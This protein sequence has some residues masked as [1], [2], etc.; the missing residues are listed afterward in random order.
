MSTMY[1]SSLVL[2]LSTFD[3]APLISS[4]M[5]KICRLD[6]RRASEG[7]RPAKSADLHYG[8]QALVVALDFDNHI[9]PVRKC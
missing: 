4:K 3:V 5:T 7:F 8:V 1:N 2:C 9:L 6:S